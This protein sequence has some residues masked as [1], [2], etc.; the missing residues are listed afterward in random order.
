MIYTIGCDAGRRGSGIKALKPATLQAI[1]DALSINTILDWRKQPNGTLPSDDMRAMFEE[2]YRFIGNR[3]N[4]ENITSSALQRLIDLKGNT[5]LLF[6]EPIPGDCP[7]HSDLAMVL[8]RRRPAIAVTHIFDAE[9]IVASELQ[10]S[11]DAGDDDEPR[12]TSWRPKPQRLQ[13]LPETA[14]ATL[15]PTSAIENSICLALQRGK[16][17]NSRKVSTAKIETKAD[18]AMLK[19]SKQLLDSPEYDAIKSLDG[20]IGKYLDSYALP[21]VLPHSDAVW[22]IPLGLVTRIQTK[23]LDF[24][25]ERKQLVKAFVAA[26]PQR[27]REAAE[28]ERAKLGEFADINDYPPVHDIEEKF[29]LDWQYVEFGVS[30][31]LRQIDSKLFEQERQRNERQWAEATVVAQQTLRACMAKLVDH[32]VDRLSGNEDG[33]PKRFNDTLITNVNEFL[34]VFDARNITNDQELKV[35]VDRARQIVRGVDPEVLRNNDSTRAYVARGFEQIKGRLDGMMTAVP[36]R[37]YRLDDE[38]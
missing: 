28:G 18:R 36:K 37:A 35:L 13:D 21:S 8:H 20:R 2:R 4:A 10:R 22:F 6:E 23:L 19:L 25:A 1:V 14:V 12:S 3:C 7:R 17:G 15:K 24:S 33:K 26:Y 27:V 29:Y 38:D 31:K 5:L 16:L 34:G 30:D 32:M 11:I 9:L